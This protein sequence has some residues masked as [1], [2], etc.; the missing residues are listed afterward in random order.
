MTTVVNKNNSQSDTSETYLLVHTFVGLRFEG[1]YMGFQ[2]GMVDDRPL[3]PMVYYCIRL[4]DLSTAVSCLERSPLVFQEIVSILRARLNSPDD[5]MIGVL[6]ENVRFSY[7]TTVRNETDPFKRTVW[8]LLGCY[9][10]LSEVIKTADDYLWF[11]LNMIRTG[12]CNQYED[13]QVWR[14]LLS[15][16]NEHVKLYILVHDFGRAWGTTLRCF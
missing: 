8:S 1:E 15:V 7:R 5:P 11:K 16:C 14:N 10:E 4:G 9:D 6:E 13:L 3:W 2:D 12:V